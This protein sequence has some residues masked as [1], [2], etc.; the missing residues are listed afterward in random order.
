MIVARLAHNLLAKD[1]SVSSSPLDVLSY[2]TCVLTVK[3][4][5]FSGLDLI[6]C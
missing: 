4:L 5:I 3:V 6:Q 1:L 2:L